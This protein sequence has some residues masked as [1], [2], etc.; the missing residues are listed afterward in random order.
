MADSV[1]PP[2]HSS[3]FAEGLGSGSGLGPGQAQGER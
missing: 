3:S 2:G 1:L